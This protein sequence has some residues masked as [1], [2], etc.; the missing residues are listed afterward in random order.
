M[1]DFVL[2]T[3]DIFYFIL[4]VYGVIFPIIF[5]ILLSS[6]AFI[7]RMTTNVHAFMATKAKGKNGSRMHISVHP[8]KL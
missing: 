3:N 5:N 8:F 7:R 4:H 6:G 2:N 1:E